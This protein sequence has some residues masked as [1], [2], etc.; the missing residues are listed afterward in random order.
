MAESHRTLWLHQGGERGVA[1][2][3]ENG[4]KKGSVI[5]SALSELPSTQNCPRTLLT[6]HELLSCSCS[7][8]L[9]PK[10]SRRSKIPFPCPSE[11]LFSFPALGRA[12]QV[13]QRFADFVTPVHGCFHK[14]HF[15]CCF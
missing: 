7:S 10:Y 9:L 2:T 12:H 4:V 6:P 15:E 13:R 8:A 5:V 11:K 1:D 14:K 3:L